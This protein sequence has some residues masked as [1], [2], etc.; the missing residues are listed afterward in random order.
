VVVLNYATFLK[1]IFGVG[2]VLVGETA[3]TKMNGRDPFGMTQE[4]AT[5]TAKYR[6]LS[7]AAAKCAASGRDDVVRG[8]AERTDNGSGG[9]S[10]SAAAVTTACK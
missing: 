2:R 6:G 9:D 3:V 5:T 4:Q 1:F 7:T 8:E 10:D